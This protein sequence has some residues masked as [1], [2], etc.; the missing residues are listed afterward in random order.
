MAFSQDAISGVSLLPDG[1]DLYIRWTS[2]VPDP[3]IFQ[4]YIDHRLAWSGTSRSCRVPLPP[5][6]S[7][8]NVWVD[9]GIVA[10][11]EACVDFSSGLPG[12][13]QRGDSVQLAWVGGTYLD[14]SGGDN[15]LGFRIYRSLTA[16]AAVDRSAA[17]DEVPAY[18]GGRIGDGFGLG[19]L[20][21]GGFGRVATNYLWTSG[22]LSSGIWQFAVVPFDKAR[23]DRGLGISY[24]VSVTT[25]PRP[26]AIGLN[27]RRLNYEYSGPSTRQVSLRWLASPS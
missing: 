22:S 16:G 9:V 4:V 1:P 24:S 18:P 23:I 12:S 15:L 8:R 11:G 26:P 17:V 20:G 14:P 27:G 10:S 6:A 3:T 21:Q 19:G 7:S 13:S 2:T 5:G 25:A